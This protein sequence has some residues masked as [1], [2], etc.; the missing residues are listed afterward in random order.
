MRHYDGPAFGFASRNFYVSFLAAEEVERNAEQY[1]GPVRLDPPEQTTTIEVPA[2][3]SAG[4]LEQTFG[5]PRETLQTYNPALLPDV[6]LGRK[7]VPRGFTLR[8]PASVSNAEAD[9]LV[10]AIPRGEQRS[11]QT[12]DKTHKVR[13]GETVSGIAARYGTSVSRIASLNNLSKRNMIRV[14]QV[15]KLPGGAGAAAAGSAP[16]QRSGEHTYVVRRGDSLALIAKRTGVP[17]RQ[18]MAFNSIANPHRIYPGQRLR[19]VRS[20]KGG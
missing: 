12:P 4:T 10:A 18:L 9:T 17:Q 6:W 7:F 5:L 19:L 15:L 11:A 2:Y 20:G 16:R 1:F 8:L 13:R 14:G 3:L